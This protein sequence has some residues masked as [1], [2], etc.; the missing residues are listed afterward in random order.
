MNREYAFYIPELDAI[1]VQCIYDNCGVG[2]HWGWA[3]CTQ[4]YQN[5]KDSGVD[6][7]LDIFFLI[8]LGEV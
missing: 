1:I 8:P 7:P 6:D 2:F 4:A 5:L 3:D